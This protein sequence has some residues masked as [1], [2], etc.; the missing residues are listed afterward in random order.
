MVVICLYINVIIQL[1]VY[2]GTRQNS[3]QFKIIRECVFNFAS[4]RNIFL[5]ALLWKSEWLSKILF[6]KLNS[7]H[8][9]WMTY[10]ENYFGYILH[11]VYS[12]DMYCTVYMRNMRIYTCI[13]PI[14]IYIVCSRY[15]FLQV[16]QNKVLQHLLRIDDRVGR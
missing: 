10:F 8:V 4:N 16:S 5:C 7:K 13:Y 15:W 1:S 6:N 3:V 14:Y 2:F 12:I 9:R 11:I